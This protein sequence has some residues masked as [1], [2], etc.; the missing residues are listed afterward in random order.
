[1]VFNQGVFFLGGS[2]F[3]DMPL[4]WLWH[5]CPL[6]S[7]LHHHHPH[8]PRRRRR[9][10]NPKNGVRFQRLS[11]E[12]DFGKE[13]PI[14]S[15]HYGIELHIY[16]FLICSHDV[17]PPRRGMKSRSKAYSSSA[18][19]GGFFALEATSQGTFTQ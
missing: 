17:L 18:S 8:P 16:R 19:P 10:W 12:A 13:W 15:N 11:A 3:Q 4:L 9:R 2:L 5:L 6:V 7:L 1:M 14:T